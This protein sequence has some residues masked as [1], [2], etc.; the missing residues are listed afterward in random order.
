MKPEREAGDQTISHTR[1]GPLLSL[2][3]K[4]LEGPSKS[5]RNRQSFNESILTKCLAC[6]LQRVYDNHSSYQSS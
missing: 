1:F 4:Q 2:K 6:L 5:V 3:E